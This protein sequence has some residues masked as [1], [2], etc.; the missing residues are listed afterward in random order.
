MFENGMFFFS[1]VYRT[2]KT[3]VQM[4]FVMHFTLCHIL[5]LVNLLKP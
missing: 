2:A 5:N 3:A 4:I 1:F